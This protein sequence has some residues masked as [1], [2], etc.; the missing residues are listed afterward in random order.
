MSTTPRAYLYYGYVLGGENE[1]QVKEYNK[2]D[3][4]LN[5]LWHDGSNSEF[6]DEANKILERFLTGATE[7]QSHWYQVS[8]EQIRARLRDEYQALR[9]EYLTVAV[10]DH[11]WNEQPSWLLAVK[12]S[13]LSVEW[14]EAKTVNPH[15]LIDLT[16]KNT[17]WR[18][19]LKRACEIL[20][21]TPLQSN[22]QW[23]LVASG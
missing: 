17:R 5:V 23:I 9:E 2:D 20:G 1:W 11:G 12:D 8:D 16:H 4:E 3:L 21:L 7:E 10:V 19:D 22:P 13:R 15:G 14:G 18:T 6:G